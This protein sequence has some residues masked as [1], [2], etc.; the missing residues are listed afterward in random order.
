MLIKIQ[1]HR[2]AREWTIFQNIRNV[3]YSD[4]PVGFDTLESYKAD[5]A[6]FLRSKPGA[7]DFVFKN[8]GGQIVWNQGSSY[9]VNE[10]SFLNED[11]HLVN[12]IFDGETYIC[13][14]EGKTVPRIHRRGFV[15][16]EPLPE[17]GVD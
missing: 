2:M 5:E 11:G 14:D 12:L 4:Q 7:I 9:F 8:A 15:R 17:C 10:I 3:T 1:H 13:N 6:T 16:N